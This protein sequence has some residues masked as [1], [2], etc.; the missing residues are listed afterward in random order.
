[1]D[2]TLPKILFTL[3]G[4]LLMISACTEPE[5]FEN[6]LIGSWKYTNY[7]TGN[8]EKIVFYDDLDYRLINY[9]SSTSQTTTVT[10]TYTYTDTTFNLKSGG[11]NPIEVVFKYAVSDDR[12]LVY[13]GKTYI[14]Q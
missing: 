4:I 9:M 11:S 3:I 14:R 13:P 7:Q 1:M 5:E 2:K 12:L 8:W 10:G 6:V